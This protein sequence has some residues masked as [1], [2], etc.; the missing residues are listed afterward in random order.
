MAIS[1]NTLKPAKGARS[2]PKRLG[3]GNSSGKGT[4]AGRGTKGQ[5]ARS[6]GRSGHKIRGMRRLIL[7]TPK[8]R[9]FK[10]QS[11]DVAAVNL[12]DLQSNFPAG[13]VVSPKSLKNKHLVPLSATVVKVLGTGDLK[14]GLKVQGCR[15]SAAAK[16]KILAAG[17]ELR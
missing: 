8:L 12:K 2:Q 14:K 10:R 9:G 17:G 7:Q 6:G 4:T 3:R 16:D 15:V 5:K 1:L 13:A 11:P